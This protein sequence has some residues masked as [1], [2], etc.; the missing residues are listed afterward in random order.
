[1]SD[2]NE[3][4]LDY[5]AGDRLADSLGKQELDDLASMVA[6]IRRHRAA[7]RADAAR[8]AEVVRAVLDEMFLAGPLRSDDAA[9]RLHLATRVA[10]HLAAP[11]L[12]AEERESLAYAKE[13]CTPPAGFERILDEVAVAHVERCRRAIATIDRMLGGGQ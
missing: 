13:I 2:L 12:S 5:Y 4:E 3:S 6:E 9:Y 10:G 7:Q 1:M 11:V 8:I